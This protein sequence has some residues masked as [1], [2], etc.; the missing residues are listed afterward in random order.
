M[1]SVC[2]C[3]G[4]S[5]SH[6]SRLAVLIPVL[7]L[8]CGTAASQPDD[9]KYDVV[10]LKKDRKV[11]KGLLV[12]YDETKP[13]VEIRVVIR[14]PG[15]RTRL[16]TFLYD[17]DQV[18]SVERLDDQEHANLEARVKAL[19]I[20]GKQFADRIHNL[21]VEAISWN[22]NGKRHAFRFK[23]ASFTL[24][25]DVKEDL[26]RRVAV[27]LE[28]V[29]AA[30]SH[31][32]PPQNPSAKPTTILLVGSLPEYQALLKKRGYFFSNP[33][34]YD[35]ITNY[36][37]CG[38]DL[39]RLGGQMEQAHKQHQKLQ[40]ELKTQ[41]EELNR[42]YKGRIPRELKE[43]LSA[44]QRSIRETETA[45]DKIFQEATRLLF[46]RL[47]HE[48][49]HAYV[50]NFVYSPESQELPRWLNEG[51]AQIFE[52]ALFEGDELRIGHADPE[53]LKRAQAALTA[54]ELV[55]LGD[56]LRSTSRQFLVAHAGDKLTSDRY[57]LTAWALA[58]Y[59]AFE[60]KASDPLGPR[61]LRPGHLSQGRCSG[62]VLR[63]GSGGGEKP[64]PVRETIPRLPR[65]LATQRD[66]E[67]TKVTSLAPV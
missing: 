43:R 30:Y 22:Y 21:E 40:K 67:S 55:P 18:S 39:E 53:R 32:L 54:R 41:Q 49:F 63:P 3:W 2:A 15:E 48:A 59:L 8:L 26:F 31:F 4:S 25:S 50:G 20:S 28:H 61:H 35:Q 47:Y 56:L 46:Q 29:Y 37:V 66:G 10:V 5:R 27:R 7:F 34:F 65:T 64:A 38:C 16:E 24:E 52:T 36:L 44:G 11:L 9:W 33:G 12:D 58:S 1:M 60:G 23:E 13:V 19:D 14:Q 62:S 51:L 6:F 57:Y 42:L 17:R 45:N